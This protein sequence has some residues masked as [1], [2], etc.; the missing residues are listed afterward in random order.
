MNNLYTF[1]LEFR[2]R[3]YIGQCEASSAI[4][5]IHVW[6][7]QLVERK[8]LGL[9]SKRLSKNVFWEI[10]FHELGPVHL[11]DT[12]NAWFFHARYAN[13]Q[14]LLHYFLTEKSQKQQAISE[15]KNNKSSLNINTINL[16]YVFAMFKGGLYISEF[17]SNSLTNVL[18]Q[19]FD[20]ISIAG[21]FDPNPEPAE[22]AKQV[23]SIATVEAIVKVSDVKN[24][25]S[26]ALVCEAEG[27]PP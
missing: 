8:T 23:R 3:V 10:S 2:G 11:R 12:D 24:I 26:L 13:V 4:D 1:F 25:W 16:F 6:R 18:N 19:W 21:H 17:K 7:N 15:S 5:A 14:Y 27:N 22:L 9:H 20:H